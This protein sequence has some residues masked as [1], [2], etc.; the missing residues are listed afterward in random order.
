MVAALTGLMLGSL[1]KV[2]PWKKTVESFV[3][4]HGEVIPVVQS[5]ILP[6]QWNLEVWF[7]LFL[8]MGGFFTV[9]FLDRLGK[10]KTPLRS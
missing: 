9:Y 4:S 2:W 8:M 6:G 1:R 3:G 7:A 5:N 10:G